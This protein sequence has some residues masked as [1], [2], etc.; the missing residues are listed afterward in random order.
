VK[1]GKKMVALITD[2]N[3]PLGGAAGNSLE[4]VESVQ[5]LKGQGPADLTELS[6]IFGCRMLAM[7]GKVKKPDDARPILQKHLDSGAA[8]RRFQE[9]VR[10]QG[11]DPSSLEDFS[12]LPVARFTEPLPAPSA[13]YIA[14]VDAELIGKGCLIL[15]AGRTKT[16]DKVDLAVGVSGMAKIGQPIEK[17]QPLIT[18]HANDQGRLAEARGMIAEAF[19]IS[20]KACHPPSLVGEII[21]P[22]K[23]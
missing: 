15:G 22:E 12:K 13:G 2:M 10:L 9:M 23:P 20:K 7:A 1:M 21:Q 11:G 5:T 16:D 18:I 14:A 8:F 19:V 4:V 3:Q 17:G 6:I